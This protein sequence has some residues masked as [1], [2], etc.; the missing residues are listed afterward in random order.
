MMKKSLFAVSSFIGFDVSHNKTL[1][2][3]LPAKF[4][5]DD[6]IEKGF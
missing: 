5:L 6:E 3:E 4:G 1:S 2:W